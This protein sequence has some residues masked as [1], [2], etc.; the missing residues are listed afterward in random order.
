[1][2]GRS[3]KRTE[4]QI[5]FSWAKSGNNKG[6][7]AL[8]NRAKFALI[9]LRKAQKIAGENAHEECEALL[10]DKYLSSLKRGQPLFL[11]LTRGFEGISVNLVSNQPHVM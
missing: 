11:K 4:R 6:I 8:L 5:L 9:D 1:M 3:Q 10:F 2:T 7:E